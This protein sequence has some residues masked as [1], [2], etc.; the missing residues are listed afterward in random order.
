MKIVP[1]IQSIYE[2]LYVANPTV[3]D[4]LSIQY[5]LRFISDL[6]I[7]DAEN[8]T[9][10]RLACD[11]S[12]LKAKT[13]PR[14]FIERF[15]IGVLSEHIFER[16]AVNVAEAYAIGY[17]LLTKPIELHTL[18]FKLGTSGLISTALI[19]GERIQDPEAIA[20]F[21]IKSLTDAEIIKFTENKLV[22]LGKNFALDV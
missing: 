19:N 1:T 6:L 12:R 20:Q 22:V 10:K 21:L 16:Y 3:N 8:A 18:Y 5:A 9:L 13:F 14:I 7:N 17:V 15:C 11:I 4:E 2:R